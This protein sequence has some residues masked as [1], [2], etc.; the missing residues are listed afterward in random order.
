MAGHLG[1]GHAGIDQANHPSLDAAAGNGNL[2]FGLYQAVVD[3]VPLPQVGFDARLRIGWP[4]GVIDIPLAR[5]PSR[6]Q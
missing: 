6:C 4:L 3:I 2:V 1:L 5:D